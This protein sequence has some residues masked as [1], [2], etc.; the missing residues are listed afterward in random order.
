MDFSHVPDLAGLR[1]LIAIGSTGSI[2]GAARATGVSQQ[3]A[4]ERLRGIEALTGLTLVRRSTRGSELT[5]SGVVVT[6]W[7]AR[8]VAL[9]EEVEDITE[10]WR[11]D[12]VSFVLGCSFS[13]EA[14]L[15]AA[16]LPLRNQQAG[17][18]VSMYRSNIDT[19]PSGPF[20]GPMVVSMR[21]M[22]SDRL[23]EVRAISARFPLAHGAPLHL[24]DPGAIGIPDLDAPDWGDAPVLAPGDVPVFWACGVTGQ[25]ALRHARLPFAMTHSPG[26]MLVTDLQAAND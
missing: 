16:G 26:H 22:P 12:L 6:E 4:S 11:D 21:A 18:N 8:L 17:R 25:Q 19:A 23:D 24:G 13:F 9:T 1:L 2:G 5:P 10:H 20:G 15:L 7:A 3:A 14:A